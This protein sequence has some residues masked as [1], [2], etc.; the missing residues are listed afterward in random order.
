M[1]IHYFADTPA[2]H[3]E[4]RTGPVSETRD[5]DENTALDVDPKGNIC[6]ITPEH[7]PERAGTPDFSYEQFAA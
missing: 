7:A 4:F 2:L 5:L 6:A 3:I 1:K